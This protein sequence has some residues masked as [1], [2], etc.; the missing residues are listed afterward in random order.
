VP[1]G[2]GHSDVPALIQ[3]RDDEVA[4]LLECFTPDGNEVLGCGQHLDR[5]PLCDRAGARG[6]LPLDHFHRLDESCRAGRVADAPSSHR[7]GPRHA[8]H[9]QSAWLQPRLDLPKRVEL[10]VTIDE[11]LVHVVG[12]HPDVRMSHQHMSQRLEFVAH[13]GD[14]SRV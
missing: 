5:S 12:Q 6:L 2:F 3:H 7:I 11:M 8:V 9:S 1:S 4:P 10:E 13:I 14:A